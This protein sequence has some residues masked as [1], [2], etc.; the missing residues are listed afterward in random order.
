[1]FVKLK[2]S[3]N[4]EARRINGRLNFE[5]GKSWTRRIQ[6]LEDDD[7]VKLKLEDGAEYKEVI[8]SEINANTIWSR[9]KEGQSIEDAVSILGT[10]P[11][12][13]QISKRGKEN[14]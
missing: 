7:K 13:F 14:V 4:R 6:W 1:M 8:C 5:N 3:D 12:P 9:F 10:A 2:T 11:K